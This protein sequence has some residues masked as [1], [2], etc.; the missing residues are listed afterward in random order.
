GLLLSALFAG[1]IAAS[2]TVAVLHGHELRVLASIGLACAVAGLVLIALA[3]N[4]P[5]AL[6]GG[7][8]LGVGDGFV[9]ATSHMVMTLTSRDVP[10][11]INRLNLF[12][13][14]GAV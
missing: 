11:G 5:L 12:F 6:I 4:W 14:I 7:G 9:I 1:S 10:S 13:A 2:A 3:P 8:L